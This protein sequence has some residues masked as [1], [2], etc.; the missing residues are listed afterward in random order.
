[1]VR[2]NEKNNKQ[3][4]CRIQCRVP[5]FREKKSPCLFVWSRFSQVESGL[6]DSKRPASRSRLAMAMAFLPNII[7]MCIWHVYSVA[8]SLWQMKPELQGESRY[9]YKRVKFS[10]MKQHSRWPATAA[11]QPQ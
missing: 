1:M 6:S 3:S 5:F 11:A 4:S 9:M 10:L 8:L 2:P 7:H